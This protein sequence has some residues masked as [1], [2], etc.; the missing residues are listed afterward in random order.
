MFEL[1]AKYWYLAVAAALGAF[2]LV[3]FWLL[4]RQA[5]E[6][7]PHFAGFLMFGPF[8]PSINSYFSRRGGLTRRELWG[9]GLVAAVMVLA[10]SF[11]PT[12]GA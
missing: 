6:E 9:W 8:W 7:K 4:S 12:R 11:G 10:I 1:I 5:S 2:S 3:A